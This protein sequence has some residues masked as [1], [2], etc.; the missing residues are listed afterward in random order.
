MVALL[1]SRGVQGLGAGLL[2]G[3]GFAVVR[4][5]LPP[6]LWTRGTALMSA[7]YGNGNFAGPAIGGVFAQFGSWRPAFALMAVAGA[8]CGAVVPCAL[9]RGQHRQDSRR[10]GGRVRVPAGR[11]C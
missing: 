2:S 9:P 5:V 4:A 11:W 6:R 3:L 7:M 1:I 8:A 10:T